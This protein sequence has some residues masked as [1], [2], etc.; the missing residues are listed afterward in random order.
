[1]KIGIIIELK[2]AVSII[3]IELNAPDS[4]SVSKALA[5]PNP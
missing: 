5:V 2:I 4:K 1:M 3:P